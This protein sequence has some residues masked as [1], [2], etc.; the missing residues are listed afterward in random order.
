LVWLKEG[1]QPWTLLKVARMAH[2]LRVNH[3]AAL[4]EA[5]IVQRRPLMGCDVRRERRSSTMKRG[6]PLH[7]LTPKTRLA[8]KLAY[9][10]GPWA[11]AF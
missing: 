4:R 2:S 10:R 7:V 6:T 9:C 1:S 11:L 8:V 3:A 5:G